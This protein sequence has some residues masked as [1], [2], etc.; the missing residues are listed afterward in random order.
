[1]CDMN[2]I[3]KKNGTENEFLNIKSETSLKLGHI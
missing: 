3:S 2:A 1:M